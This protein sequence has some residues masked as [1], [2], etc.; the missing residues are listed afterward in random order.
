VEVQDAGGNRVTFANPTVTLALAA[1]PSGASLTGTLSANAVN[2]LA[3]FGNLTLTKA[4][5]SYQLRASATNL[6]AGVGARFVVQ[7]AEPSRLAVVRTPATTVAGTALSPSPQMEIL[8]TYGNRVLYAS[9]SVTV[10][11][12]GSGSAVTGL[13]R[14]AAVRGLVDFTNLVV[15]QSGGAYQLVAEAGALTAAT[16]SAFTVNPAA[17]AT[18]AFTTDLP[19]T[20]TAGS[21]IGPAVIVTAYDQFNNVATTSTGNVVLAPSSATQVTV[22]GTLT[23]A[24][25]SGVATFN[26]LSVRTAGSG[27]RLTATLNALPVI[28]SGTLSVRPAA[29]NRLAMVQQPPA[30]AL[31]GTA[32]GTPMSVRVEDSFGNLVDTA[33]TAVT[34][35]L[36]G[37]TAGAVL[38]G[39][40]TANAVSGIALFPGLS[41][42]RV[43]SGYTIPFAAS[44]LSGVNSSAIAVGVGPAAALRYLVQ[45]G[46]TAQGQPLTNI[47]Q[48]EIVDAG[49]NRVPTATNRVTVSI[50]GSTRGATLAGATGVNAVN[51][52][53]RFDAVGVTLN[54]AGLRLAAA[55]TGL[56]GTTSEPFDVYGALYSLEILSR[57]RA[58]FSGDILPTQPVLRLRDSVGV[59]VR[60]S[61]SITATLLGSTGGTL[62]GTRT[63]ASSNGMATFTN[64]TMTGIGGVRYQLEFSGASTPKA[65]DSVTLH[66]IDIVT[67]PVANINNTVLPSVPVVRILDGDDNIVTNQSKVIVVAVDSGPSATMTGNSVTT[68]NGLATFSSLVLNG[69]L[70]NKYRLSLSAPGLS[71]VRTS[72]VQILEQTF[73]PTGAGRTAPTLVNWTVPNEVAAIDVWVT[74]GRT[75]RWPTSGAM[76]GFVTGTLTVSPGLAVQIAPG[77][78]GISTEGGINALGFGK[79]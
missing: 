5:S 2:G 45:P 18:L 51:G 23:R 16:T 48:L 7:S 22:L 39:M 36:S 26:D 73:S 46:A 13:T 32:W 49:G 20:V 58:A 68:V 59:T 71:A 78:D 66:R 72:A 27:Y 21:T 65:R 42:D 53:A 33:T 19:A 6:T 30:N 8:D 63:I 38:G 24:L 28:T 69:S 1:A 31:G 76:S 3:T 43:G 34:A 56:T 17:A 55:S 4:D 70:G 77:N 75:E 44:G 50:S 62:G 40:R 79:G 67:Q 41:I 60:D 52:I 15:N 35:S 14:R 10:R 57:P 54:E 25:S 29:P 9:D 12:T 64:L 74:G 47:P 37:G 11:L 61:A